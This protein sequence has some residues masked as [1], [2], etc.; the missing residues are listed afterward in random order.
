MKALPI[1]LLIGIIMIVGVAGAAPVILSGSAY[2]ITTT[3]FKQD[4]VDAD[5]PTALW[6]FYGTS[7]GG[8]SLNTSYVSGAFGT[9]NIQ[10]N[11]PSYWAGRTIYYKGCSSDGECS[12]EGS[13]TLSTPASIVTG[14][15]TGIT[16]NGFNVTITGI[17]GTGVWIE[18]GSNTG[19]WNWKTPVYDNTGSTYTVEVIGAP[20]YSQE[21]VYYR[22]CDYTGCGAEMSTV[23]LAVTTI[24]TIPAAKSAFNN[25]TRSRF[26]PTTIGAS[27]LVA[28][29]QVAPMIIIIGFAAMMYFMGLWMRTKTARTATTVGILMATFLASSSAGLYLGLP[30]IW[31]AIAGGVLALAFT[32]ALWSLIHR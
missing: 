25:I 30:V 24:P 14:M 31:S 10:V 16:S 32:G 6:I 7:S 28:Y 15:A 4:V 26:N 9:A 18:F 2:D 29:T 20:L 17:S 5:D 1:F 21:H 19:I 11:V 3:S 23:L 13:V 27:L 22:A 8:E 12:T